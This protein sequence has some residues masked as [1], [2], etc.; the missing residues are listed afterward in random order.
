MARRDPPNRT[1]QV[2]E[3]VYRRNGR[4]FVRV[5]DPVSGKRPQQYPTEYSL[6]NTLDGA[7]RLKRQLEERKAR[8][9]AGGGETV[10]AVCGAVDA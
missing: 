1:V 6:P 2:A 5:A 10:R 9:R 4:Y 8:T 3:G 7:R